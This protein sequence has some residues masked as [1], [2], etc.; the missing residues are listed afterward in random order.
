[1]EFEKA[2]ESPKPPLVKSKETAKLQPSSSSPTKTLLQK[3]T[4]TTVKPIQGP[5][6]EALAR[7]AHH[8]LEDMTTNDPKISDEELKKLKSSYGY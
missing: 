7:H 2:T 4:P 3:P 8:E 5:S 1:M 6:K